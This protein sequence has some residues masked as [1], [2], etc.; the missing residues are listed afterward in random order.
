[1]SNYLLRS[2]NILYGK[3]LL[4]LASNFFSGELNTNILFQ[5]II[6]VGK[7]FSIHCLQIIIACL[8]LLR[9]IVGSA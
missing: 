5:N 4:Y 9:G 7:S 1:M 6:Q 2:C 8:F 3:K